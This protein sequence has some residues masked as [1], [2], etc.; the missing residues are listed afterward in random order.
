MVINNINLQEHTL[1]IELSEVSSAKVWVDS[2]KN[3]QNK[4]AEEDQLH[5]IVINDI[6]IENS[7]ATVTIS[8]LN[9]PGYIVTVVSDT[10]VSTLVIDQSNIYNRAIMLFSEYCDTCL[11]KHRKEKIVL[12]GLFQELLKYSMDNELFEDSISHFKSLCDVLDI[13]IANKRC[14]KCK[15]CINNCCRL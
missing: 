7:N 6:D 8:D 11:D 1:T 9:E 5:T 10:K 12:Y 3:E 2:I 4:Y 15:I 14:E 13:V